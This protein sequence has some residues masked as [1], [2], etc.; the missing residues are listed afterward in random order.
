M[1]LQS[2]KLVKGIFRASTF[3]DCEFQQADLSDCIF[4]RA[5][6]R[7]AKGLTSGQLLKC[8]SIKYT[9]LDAALAA[10]INAV[11]PKLLKN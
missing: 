4:E 5:D 8:A 3:K 11:N 1:I 7:G 10:E 6:L 2:H 9:R